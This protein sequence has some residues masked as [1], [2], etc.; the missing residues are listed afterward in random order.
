MEEVSP[1]SFSRVKLRLTVFLCGLECL[2]FGATITGWA[3]IT[4]IFK[5]D[6]VCSHLCSDNTT[7]V[8]QD[9]NVSVGVMQNVTLSIEVRSSDYCFATFLSLLDH[10]K[11]LRNVIK[12]NFFALTES[13]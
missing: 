2:L 12:P 6:G 10:S 7:E 3:S 1:A 9:A 8:A 13:S 4:Y 11:K 5:E